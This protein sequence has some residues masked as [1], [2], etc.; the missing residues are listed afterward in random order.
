MDPITLALIGAG[1][2]ALKSNEEKNIWADQQKAEAEKSRYGAWTKQW[3]NN[4]KPPTGDMSHVMGGAATGYL[5]GKNAGG[6]GGE[7]SV[8]EGSELANAGDAHESE[9]F[10]ITGPKKYTNQSNTNWAATGDS[11]DDYLERRNTNVGYLNPYDESLMSRT[12]K[13]PSFENW[14]SRSK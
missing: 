6:I 9:L 2:G 3:G 5:L 13:D 11:F 8:D 4:L 12:S 14:L 10:N 7:S 1:I